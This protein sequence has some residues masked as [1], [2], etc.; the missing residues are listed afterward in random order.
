MAGLPVDL[1]AQLR[2]FIDL[3][4]D[5]RCLTHAA[6]PYPF[7]RS[8]VYANGVQI[9][10]PR[11]NERRR[12]KPWASNA[13]QCGFGPQ[14][15]QIKIHAENHVAAHYDEGP[16]GFWIEMSVHPGWRSR[17]SSPWA[18]FCDAVGVQ[19]DAAHTQTQFKGPLYLLNNLW[20]YK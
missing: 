14:G 2:R 1:R 17:T 6:L 4:Q 3:N 18:L 7:L 12:L 11:V 5:C 13:K 8:H 9:S 15:G 19:V 16:L 20:R 10:K